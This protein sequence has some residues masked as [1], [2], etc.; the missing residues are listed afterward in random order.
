MKKEQGST[1]T[2]TA[3]TLLCL[4]SVVLASRVPFFLYSV[5]VAHCICFVFSSL[6]VFNHQKKER[7]IRD[8]KAQEGKGTGR[9]CEGWEF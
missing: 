8:A 7:K 2:T 3:T 1:T 4:F 9:I 5:C 6:T